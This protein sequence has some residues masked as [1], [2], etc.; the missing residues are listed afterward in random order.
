MYFTLLVH[1]IARNFILEMN[2]KCSGEKNE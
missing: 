1:N 2:G